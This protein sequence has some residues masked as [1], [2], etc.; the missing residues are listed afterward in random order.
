MNK[1]IYSLKIMEELV[2]RGYIPIT[3]MP[4]PKFPKYQCWIF[5]ATDG[6]K[7]DLDQILSSLEGGCPRE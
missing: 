1:I 6:F 5:A 7:E 2:K 3:S 4:N